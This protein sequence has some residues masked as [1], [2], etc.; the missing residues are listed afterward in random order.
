[1]ETTEGEFK[2]PWAHQDANF[3]TMK[4]VAF[5][6]G[7][8]YML[9]TDKQGQ[10]HGHSWQFQA[11]VKVPVNYDSF[12]K[13]ED[14]DKLLNKLLEPYQRNIL[15][16]VSPFD[17]VEPLTE[18]ITVYFFNTL[19]DALEN[20]NV[21]LVRLTVWENPT[22]GI[23]VTSRLPRF[24][25]SQGNQ[26]VSVAE[27]CNDIQEVAAS[28]DKEAIVSEP[29]LEQVID[30]T[31]EKILVGDE[32]EKPVNTAEIVSGDD[33]SASEPDGDNCNNPV[34]CGL[35]S[36]P[37]G[38]LDRLRFRLEE[39]DIISDEADEDVERPA[40]P[41]W[42]IVIGILIISGVAILAYWPLLNAP[43][44]KI[45]PWG[46]DTWGHLFKAEFLY[47]E[48]INGNYYPQ[49]MSDWYNGCQPFRYWA[50]LPYYVL[51]LI[52]HFTQNIFMAGN[53]YVFAC[54]L[55]GG[56]GC[57]LL[58]RR[59]GLWPAVMLGIIWVMWPDNVQI[60]LSEGNLPRILATGLLPL[61]FYA[62]IETVKDKKRI[63]PLLITL[64]T[65]HIVILCHAMIG[66]IYIICLLIFG[67]L[68]WLFGG[69]SFTGLIRGMSSI[70][71]G[72]ISS[73]WWLLPSLKGG[74]TS[75]G[76]GAA[77]GIRYV[78]PTISFNP[79]FR[80]SNKEEFYWGI[81]L[82]A[83]TLLSV[84]LWRKKPAWA[85]SLIITGLFLVVLTF[86]VF[87]WLHQLLPLSHILWPLRFTSFASFALLAGGFAI[88]FSY[89]KNAEQSK[90]NYLRII[91]AGLFVVLLID[92]GYSLKV[93]VET[94][95]EPYRIV[96]CA[97]EIE[98]NK[99][100]RVATLDASSL[101]SAPS[102]FFSNKS[103]REQVFGWAWQGATTARNI[104]LLNTA[105]QKGY[106]PFLFRELTYLG[107]TDLVVK[108]SV[109]STE[110]IAEFKQLA[111]QNGFRQQQR[112]EGV[113]YWEKDQAPYLITGERKCLAI[114]K[115][116]DNY[117]LQFPA[118]ERGYSDTIDEYNSE[119]LKQYPMLI[120]AG[121]QWQQQQAAEEKIL[122]YAEAGGK[123]IVDMTGF[124]NDIMS[125]RAK[126]LGVYTEPVELKG[127]I[128][129]HSLTDE[130]YLQ[131]FSHED[132]PWESLVPQA[133]DK[134]EL[135][136]NYMGNQAALYGYKYYKDKKVWFLGAN[137]A[138]Y[139]FL[140]K[141]PAAQNILQEILQLPQDQAEVNLISL[142]SYQSNNQG[143]KLLYHN[144]QPLDA[145]I[146]IAA[147]DGMEARIDNKRVVLDKFEN[148]LR[149]NLPAGSHSI[150]L[151]IRSSPV[152]SWG[153]WIS[154]LGLGLILLYCF[155]IRWQVWHNGK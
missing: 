24:F 118:I 91:T 101:G 107:A 93:L 113:S 13:F 43:L 72:V 9:F 38:I 36:E 55:L 50:P 57:L 151:Q 67:L 138:Y 3:I 116:A 46:S 121:A 144:D 99:G 112:F 155:W 65:I 84:F 89:L 143:Y 106:Y 82:L 110:S 29:D 41:L 51:A 130:V 135:S 20:F 1:M 59:L 153:K 148:L 28:T 96:H 126:F 117:A 94:R 34:L 30:Q 16:E 4:I 142:K 125:R 23:E 77:G 97:E 56:L 47:R 78:S 98:H 68:W 104:M 149:I 131:S 109:L 123:V 120:L 5:L 92:S 31:I 42:K 80:F 17:I 85:K 27:V 129:V 2:T 32:L 64:A 21:H 105:L 19:D 52:N 127:G 7:R 15:N 18:N 81:A 22:K 87:S 136:F 49:F 39:Y 79:I 44:D 122:K 114:G 88:S 108:E 83:I 8:H 139:S 90:K 150:D 71:L 66:A 35:S 26:S 154:Y 111:Y 73:A 54:A 62:F 70:L 53:Y 33:E 58:A 140:T 40:Y 145:I 6:N 76:A 134:V 69:C 11:E 115:Y 124:P 10:T 128:T 146:P 102:Y 137:L 14:L 12:V 103:G 95:V 133:L 25:S 86:P 60:A 152:Y 147:L 48:I 75:M 37:E 100:W 74:L 141:D 63:W 132:G 61:L 45:F 119:Y